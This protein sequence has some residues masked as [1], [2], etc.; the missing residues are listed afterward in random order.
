MLYDGVLSFNVFFIFVCW[1]CRLEKDRLAAV[2]KAR[3]EERATAAQQAAKI[4]Q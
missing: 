2:E 1:Y 3:Q 4:A